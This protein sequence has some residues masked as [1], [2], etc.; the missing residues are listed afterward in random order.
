MSVPKRGVAAA[1]A[2]VPSIGS[3]TQTNSAPVFSETVFFADDAVVRKP[4][5]DHPPHE[6]LGA[7][8]SDGHRRLVGLGLHGE[9]GIGEM[10]AD[11]VA[12]LAGQF[13]QE[14]AINLEVHA[15]NGR[16]ECRKRHEKKQSGNYGNIETWKP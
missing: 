2:R 14:V 16:H 7:A 3:R 9:A 11:E 1:K 15:E 12:A 4:F 10:R 6:L 5:A 8:V 13:E